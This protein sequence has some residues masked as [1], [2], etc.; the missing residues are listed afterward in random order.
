MANHNQN[1]GRSSATS[2]DSRPGWRPQDPPATAH[3]RGN[4]D[5]HDYRSWRERNYR[6]DD[7]HAAD[8]D[9]RRWEGGRGSELGYPG[10]R[11][12]RPIERYGQGQS[13]YSAG[14]Y[15]DDRSQQIQSRNELAP[16]P[17][18]FEDRHYNLGVGV[19]DRFTGRGQSSYWQDRSGYD[20]ERYGT[21]GGYGG[22]RGVE[23]ERTAGAWR[24]GSEWR[25]GASEWRGYDQG[26]GRDPRIDPRMGPTGGQSSQ[27]MGYQTGSYGRGYGP[28]QGAQDDWPQRS[29]GPEQHVHRGTGPHRGKGPLGYQR[30]DER[31]RELVSEALADDDRIDASQILVSVK[32][33]EVTLSGVV[34]DRRTRR[35]AEDCAAAIGGVRDV[36]IQLRVKDDRQTRSSQT[37]VASASGSWESSSG[38]AMIRPESETAQLDKKHRA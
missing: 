30:S 3:S 28:S 24:G 13:G 34:D 22:G 38:H 37:T 5:D 23:S 16:S 29:R 18:S 9:P 15:G 10:E 25:G 35:E 20:P 32:D 17:G 4:E 31:I 27:S 8:R 14:R 12:S 1:G 2:D 11:D 33:G 26:S 6:D 21:H 36:Q 7:R 19:D